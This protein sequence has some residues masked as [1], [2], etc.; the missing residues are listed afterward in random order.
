MQV[1]EVADRYT[2]CVLKSER[3]PSEE[4]RKYFADQARD[5]LDAMHPALMGGVENCLLRRLMEVNTQ[6]WD[7]END[8]RTGAVD[9]CKGDIEAMANIGYLALKVRD[10]NRVRCKVKNDIC[11]RFGGYKECKH[12][13]GTQT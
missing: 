8:I 12:N 7:T 10:L 9:G 5:Y 2:I 4:E 6:I 13:Y 11:D 3:L 1:S